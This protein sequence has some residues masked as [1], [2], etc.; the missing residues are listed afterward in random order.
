M[1]YII[2]ACKGPSTVGNR[3]LGDVTLCQNNTNIGI[4]NI[5]VILPQHY[6][7]T[8]FRSISLQYLKCPQS[9]S[10]GVA[11]FEPTTLGSAIPRSTTDLHA[12]EYN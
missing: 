6:S 12:Q 8:D 9:K 2:L 5:R 7:K 10:K 1:D 4:V 3:G 11:G